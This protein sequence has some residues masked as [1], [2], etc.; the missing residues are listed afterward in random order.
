MSFNDWYFK[1]EDNF[2]NLTSEEMTS[3]RL[4]NLTAEKAIKGFRAPY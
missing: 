2:P 1:D 4:A 3:A